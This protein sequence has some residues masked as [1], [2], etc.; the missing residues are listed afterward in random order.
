M[1]E[2]D[3]AT[4]QEICKFMD[5]QLER[6]AKGKIMD[7]SAEIEVPEM[8]PVITIYFK[9]KLEQLELNADNADF[10]MLYLIK[11]RDNDFTEDLFMKYFNTYRSEFIQFIKSE[12]KPT[13][14]WESNINSM[15]DKLMNDK[16]NHLDSN[17]RKAMMDNF[18][19]VEDLISLCPI[20][21]NILHDVVNEMN[22]I[23]PTLNLTLKYK[24]IP[25]DENNEWK[26]Y[27]SFIYDTPESPQ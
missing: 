27:L 3:Y 11:I 15:R 19:T 21:Y 7:P 20:V 26:T 18:N 4:K 14:F 16:F 17:E 12:M 10:F 9:Y 25:I 8:R 22:D 5:K 23:H 13:N 6:F 2:F 24:P 1:E